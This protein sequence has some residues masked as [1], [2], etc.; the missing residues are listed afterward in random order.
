MAKGETLLGMRERK[1]ITGY[2][3]ERRTLL[4]V[5]GRGMKLG[6]LGR[7]EATGKMGKEAGN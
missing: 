2:L 5:W 6:T 3:E 1:D 7:W 4:G